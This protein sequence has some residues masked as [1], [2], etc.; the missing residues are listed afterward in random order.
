[1]TFDQLEVV[2]K[3]EE[4][5]SFKAAAAA[6]RR[7]Q[8]TLTVTVQKLEAE[9]GV[10]LFSR[11][12]YRPKLTEAGRLFLDRARET[13][14]SFRRLAVLGQE[15]GPGKVEPRLTVIV[16][17]VARFETIA[18]IFETCLRKMAPTE[19]V[20]RSEILTGG[21]EL[22]RS[23]EADFA[24]AAALSDKFG[25]SEDVEILPLET[26]AMLP[27]VAAVLVG[28]ARIDGSWLREQPQIVVSTARDT[29]V[30]RGIMQGGTHCYVTDH[31]LKRRMILAG[32]GWGRLAR[33]E[34]AA[35]LEAGKLVPI[36]TPEAPPF[37]LE[38]CVMR[39]L[40]RPL[41]PTGAAIWARLAS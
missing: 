3:I 34:V 25:P 10:Q 22:L 21:L 39:S 17:P 27:V 2:E 32:L 24:V 11:E 12:E 1:M 37:T 23:G 13:L 29:A 5:G 41:G 14:R 7:T 18:G 19:L 31:A 9:L 36:Q 33:H 28:S 30:S 4:L 26:V 38:L 15:L 20:L 16:D 40:L 8:P 35:E 6:L